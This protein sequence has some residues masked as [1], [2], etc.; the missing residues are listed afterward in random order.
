MGAMNA[1]SVG[2]VERLLLRVPEAAELT[3]LGKSK[4]Y[5]LVASGEWPSVTIGRS[6]RVPLA[7]LRAWVE[8]QERRC[9]RGRAPGASR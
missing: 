2:R 6:I 4:A 1:P 9:D 8:E 5:E 3:G 7:G